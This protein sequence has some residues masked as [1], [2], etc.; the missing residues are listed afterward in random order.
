MGCSSLPFFFSFLFGWR[1][2]R[3]CSRPPGPG[4]RLIY[5]LI[6]RSYMRSSQTAEPYECFHALPV[7]VDLVPRE[8]SSDAQLLC[9]FSKA[10]REKIG[11]GRIHLM[12]KWLV[13]VEVHVQLGRYS[14]TNAWLNC[15]RGHDKDLKEVGHL[16][17]SQNIFAAFTFKKFIMNCDDM[18]Y[19]KEFVVF[20]VVL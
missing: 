9:M 4:M 6:N 2:W 1:R 8:N 15:K 14:V 18:N 12:V 13:C 7:L 5:E 19:D 17:C 11:L 3:G 16:T 10:I 20:N